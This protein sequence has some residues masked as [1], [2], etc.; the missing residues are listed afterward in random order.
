MQRISKLTQ[1]IGE[2]LKDPVGQPERVHLAPF[3]SE[4]IERNGWT[5]DVED[6]S[7]G[8]AVSVDRDRMRSVVENLVRNAVES[9]GP[10]G[11]VRIRVE[12]KGDRIRVSVLDRG[13]GLGA[14]EPDRNFEPFYTTK[15][16]GSG[17][18]LAMSKRFIEAAGAALE[19][20]P[21]AGG[22]LEARMSYPRIGSES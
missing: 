14:A 6:R 16:S 19:L 9:G 4:V 8:S 3:I 5:V 2:F 13:E 11:E 15:S 21:R 17:I 18:G 22:G 10:P 20:L 1:R 12:S 7:S